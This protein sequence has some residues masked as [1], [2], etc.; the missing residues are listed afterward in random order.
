MAGYAEDGKAGKVMMWSLGGI[1]AVRDGEQFLSGLYSKYI[2][3]SNFSRFRM[4]SYD[5][6]FERSQALPD[7]PER[8]KV[9]RML[10]DHYVTYAPILFNTYRIQNALIYPWVQGWKLNSLNQYPF[11][12]LDID[13]PRQRAALK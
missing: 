12:Y 7:G 1:A 2:D 13:V 9:Y 8:N 6:L 3:Y 10:S 5:E 11:L 4:K